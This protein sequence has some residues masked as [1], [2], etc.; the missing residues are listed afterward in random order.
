MGTSASFWDRMAK[1]YSK[2]TVPNQAVYEQKL[3]KTQEY[4]D[5][6]TKLF[7]FGCGTG[8]TAIHHAPFVNHVH[9][10]DI[11]AKMLEIAHDKTDAQGIENITFEQATIE[12]IE[13][14]DQSYDAVLGLSILHLLEDRETSILKVYRM[15]KP[16]GIFV[17]STVCLTGAMNII[18]PLLAVGSF[19]GLLPLIRFITPK[20]LEQDMIDAGFQNEVVWQPEN[21]DAVFIIAR[22]PA[23]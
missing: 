3:K 1:G 11:S 21:S 13:V 15:L 8:T 9:A 20:T 4:F 23:V 12:N 7:E 22:K 19:L 16:D 17:T 10:T 14:P 6:N 5:P 18:R 2:K